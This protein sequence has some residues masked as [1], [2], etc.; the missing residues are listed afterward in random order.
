MLPVAVEIVTETTPIIAYQVTGPDGAQIDEHESAIFGRHAFYTKAT[1]QHSFCFMQRRTGG[2]PMQYHMNLHF[3]ET[4]IDYKDLAKK[5]HLDELHLRVR[6]LTDLLSWIRQEQQYMRGRDKEFQQ[7]TESIAAKVMWFSIAQSLA[8]LVIT[9]F[10]VRHMKLFFQEKN[11]IEEGF[12]L[13]SWLDA[14]IRAAV[15]EMH[16]WYRTK[17]TQH[18]KEKLELETSGSRD[19]MGEER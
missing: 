1:G 9:I 6:K 13:L 4:A 5:S 12:E 16:R 7:T 17:Q 8:V 18:C 3:A 15:G 2:A 10:Q 11:L 14:R 19:R